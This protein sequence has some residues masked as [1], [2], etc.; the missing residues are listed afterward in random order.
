MVRIT[1]STA[2]KPASHIAGFAHAR[3]G[4]GYYNARYWWDGDTSV[5]MGHSVS[6]FAR[7]DHIGAILLMG[8]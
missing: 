3:P 8:A 4:L 7:L 2:R 5:R 1:L 6:R